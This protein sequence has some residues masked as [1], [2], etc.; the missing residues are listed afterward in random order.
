MQRRWGACSAM[1]SKHFFI[2]G[3]FTDVSALC[4][5]RC[6]DDLQGKIPLIQDGRRRLLIIN[7]YGMRCRVYWVR[8][9]P[10]YSKSSRIKYRCGSGLER[11]YGAFA[12][13]VINNGGNNPNQREIHRDVKEAQNTDSVALYPAGAT[14]EGHLSATI[15][16]RTLRWTLAICSCFSTVSFITTT[17]MRRATDAQ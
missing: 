1:Y 6:F 13:C 7:G 8:L 16:K 10:V 14:D 17:R 11:L 9:H 12:G 3:R 15:S 4:A 2:C 5:D